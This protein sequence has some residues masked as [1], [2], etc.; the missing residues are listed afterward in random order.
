MST[1]ILE[2]S[3]MKRGDGEGKSYI[4]NDKASETFHGICPGDVIKVI[5]VSSG[6]TLITGIMCISTL[7]KACSGCIFEQ[8][9]KPHILRVC[10]HVPCID[11]NM[12]P[13]KLENVLEEI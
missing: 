3:S 9:A 2:V 12:I 8:S 6:E 11:M 10:K 13:M 7:E 1:R 5:D 4:T